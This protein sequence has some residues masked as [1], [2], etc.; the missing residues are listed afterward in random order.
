MTF[1]AVAL[2]HFFQ[3]GDLATQAG[4]FHIE[5]EL[6]FIQALFGLGFDL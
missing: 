3:F 2:V 5:L 1:F 4:H 6:R